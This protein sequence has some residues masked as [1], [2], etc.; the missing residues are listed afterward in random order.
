MCAPY[1]VGN[2]KEN[3]KSDIPKD[4]FCEIQY[5]AAGIHELHICVCTSKREYRIHMFLTVTAL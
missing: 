3:F 4:K 2:L 5:V 1:V